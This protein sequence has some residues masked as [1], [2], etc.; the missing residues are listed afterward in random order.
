WRVAICAL[1][2]PGDEAHIPTGAEGQLGNFLALA[3]PWSVRSRRNRDV[4]TAAAGVECRDTVGVGCDKGNET[5]VA[6]VLRE[7]ERNPVDR[8]S[9]C[10]RSIGGRIGAG[11]APKC[12]HCR[13]DDRLRFHRT[14]TAAKPSPSAATTHLSD[15]AFVPPGENAPFEERQRSE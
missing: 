3:P 15:L 13:E 11:R 8:R 14:P 12:D 1:G 4:P 9:D 2:V 5:A 10:R 6:I 7:V